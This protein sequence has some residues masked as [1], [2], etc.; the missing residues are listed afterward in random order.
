MIKRRIQNNKSGVPGVHRGIYLDRNII[1]QIKHLS[2]EHSIS[3]N[4]IIRQTIVLG[5]NSKEFKKTLSCLYKNVT[6]I[7]S[8]TKQ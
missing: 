6:F 4:E 8:N 5:M 3:G 2:N 1:E 7:V